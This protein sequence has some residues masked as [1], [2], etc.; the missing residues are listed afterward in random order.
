MTIDR[1]KWL[2]LLQNFVDV[3]AITHTKMSQTFDKENFQLSIR[4]L[5]PRPHLLLS[6]VPL[7]N[8]T[9]LN[10]VLIEF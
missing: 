3:E 4:L 1:D 6:A 8:N 10:A 5:Y 9:V 7:T 2:P